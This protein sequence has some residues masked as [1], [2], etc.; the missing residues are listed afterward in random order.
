MIF[1]SLIEINI[2]GS[3]IYKK[4]F[5]SFKRLC[6]TAIVFVINFFVLQP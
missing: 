4:K 2:Q 3:D 6:K 1:V 5:S